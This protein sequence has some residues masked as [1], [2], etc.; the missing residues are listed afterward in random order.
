M[1]TQILLVED[2][3]ISAR[4][5]SRA[6]ENEGYEVVVAS[7]GVEGLSKATQNIPSLVILDVMLP[8][9]DVF[10]VCQRLRDQP[11]TAKIPILM[12][13]AKDQASDVAAGEKVGADLYLVKS[14]GRSSIVAA[15]KS[16]LSADRSQTAT[17]SGSTS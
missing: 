14:T 15:V 1:N 16:L 4:L 8:G 11:A 6:L 12:L 13:S 5:L 17:A 7:N 10:E 2:E 9:L 3:K